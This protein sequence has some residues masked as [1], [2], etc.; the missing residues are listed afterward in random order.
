M[1]LEQFTV[2]PYRMKRLKPYYD[3]YSK[4]NLNVIYDP[5]VGDMLRAQGYHFDETPRSV[6]KVEKLY[7]ALSAYAPGKIPRP[8]PTGYYQAGISLAYKCFARPDNCRT[9]SIL[10]LTPK[11]IVELTSNP[12]GSAGL[13]CYGVDKAHSQMRALERGIQTILG[14]KQ[15]EPCLA[16]K[17]TQFNDKTRLVWGYPYS[18]TVVE[19]LI[20][21]PLIDKFKDRVT[22]MAFAMPTVA[23]GAK[24]RVSSYKYKYCYSLDMSQFDA[25]ISAELI[26]VAFKI[27]ST[28]FDLDEIEPTTGKS[29]RDILGVVERYF[30]H[31][32]IVMPNGKIYIGKCHGVPSGSYFTQMV[33]SVV[34]TIICGAVSARFNLK[35]SRKSIFVLGDD[36]NFWSNRKVSLDVIAKFVNSNFHVKL[37]GSEKS[38]L[39]LYNEV[40]HFLGRDWDNGLPTLSL[41]GILAR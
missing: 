32:T 38:E 15:P 21:R 12:S 27:L 23:L 1:D 6:Y 25:T 5:N 24:L 10:P 34:N 13:T 9:L 22:P 41:D 35:V 39:S 16:F 2:R 17:R 33:D 36:L 28:W 29:V 4:D 40:I 7:S 30:I 3:M 31:T 14:E 26:H 8:T 18:M 11:T 37:H 20:A 19:G